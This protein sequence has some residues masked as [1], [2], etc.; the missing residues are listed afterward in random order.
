[1]SC[2]D[3]DEISEEDTERKDFH[4]NFGLTRLSSGR[5]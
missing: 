4:R 3:S 2:F 1:M 5:N